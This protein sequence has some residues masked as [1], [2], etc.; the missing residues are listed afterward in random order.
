MALMAAALLGATGGLFLAGPFGERSQEPGPVEV[1]FAQDMAA[2]H[3]QGVE[4]ANVALQRTTNPEIR[5]I[6]FDITSTQTEQMGRMRGWLALW[7]K[8]MRPTG[9]RMSWMSDS[10]SPSNE[11][12]TSNAASMPGMASGAELDRLRSL[13]GAQ[14]ET[15][16]LRL[17][18]RHHQGGAP[19]MR[20]VIER[21]EF[22]AVRNL[23]Q[24][25]LIAQTTEVESMKQMLA[26]RDAAPL[27]GPIPE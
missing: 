17:M 6:A 26:E 19:M 4:M 20:T 18:I 22:G 1:G 2:H 21:A 8:P 25:M 12:V 13:S 10:K 16:F 9:D 24:Q 14:M 11:D 27:P 7:S 5:Q 15:Y 3:R 23:A